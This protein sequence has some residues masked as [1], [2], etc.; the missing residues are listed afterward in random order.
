MVN[1]YHWLSKAEVEG[2]EKAIREFE[3]STCCE[4]VCAVASRSS[5]YPRSI[6]LF[7]LLGS[8][9]GF[10]SAGLVA[11]WSHEPGAWEVVDHVSTP[12]SLLGIVVGFAVGYLLAARS[13]FG[14]RGVYK[15]PEVDEAVQTAAWS[16]FGHHKVSQ[17]EKGVGLLIYI[18]LHE[19]RLTVLADR[20][21]A[22]VL[23]D[24]GLKALRDAGLWRLAQGGKGTAFEDV[25]KVAAGRLAE[26]FPH[27]AE[28]QNE[29]ADALLFVHPFPR[30]M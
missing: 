21:A 14:F 22:K 30:G 8:L 28:D 2:V 24:D 15:P 3:T 12:A 16:L 1:A 10:L 20:G 19:H 7:T 9:I 13:R 4:A 26:A 23:G 11:S 5:S 25:L 29:L 18:S 27:H 6:T 17:T